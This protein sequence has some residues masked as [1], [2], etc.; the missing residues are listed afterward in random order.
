MT[1]RRQQLFDYA[2]E[3]NVKIVTALNKSDANRIGIHLLNP[4][5]NELED[6]IFSAERD[7]FPCIVLHSNSTWFNNRKA[8]K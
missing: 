6:A 3:V 4:G 5:L 8:S 2:D 7:L 1:T